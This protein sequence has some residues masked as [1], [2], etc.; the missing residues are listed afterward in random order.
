MSKILYSFLSESFL[1]CDDYIDTYYAQVTDLEL[2]NELH[3]YREFCIQ[4]IQ[5]MFNDINLYKHELKIFSAESLIDIPRLMQTA[6][7]M[8]QIT[9]P[10][11]IFKHSYR[12]SQFSNVLAEFNGMANEPVNRAS[13]SKTAKLLK[14]LAPMVDVGYVK[15]FPVDYFFEPK[16]EIPLTAPA[17]PDVL[18]ENIMRLYVDNADIKSFSRSGQYITFDKTLQPRREISIK[19]DSNPHKSFCYQLMEQKIESYDEATN[20]AQIV[21]SIPFYLPEKESFDAWVSQSLYKSAL[22]HH[23]TILKEIKFAEAFKSQ[24]ITSSPFVGKLLNCSVDKDIKSF[25]AECVL[26]FDLRFFENID[27]QT[28]MSIRQNDG[29]EFALFRC[30]LEK[31][32]RVLRAE[33]NTD[34]LKSKIADIS[35]EMMSVQIA[36]LD[37][38]VKN[39]KKGALANVVIGVAGLAGSIATSGF[40][41]LA[42]AIALANGYKTYAEYQQ[43]IRENPSFFLWKVK[44]KI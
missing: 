21:M 41:L 25:T 26:N 43:K 17:T 19:F 10:D 7:Y 32:L 38:K 22:I 11:P 6:L 24:Y 27:I 40:S 30:E 39:M 20:T 31:Q 3:K 35:H 34:V 14:K 28:L 12:N 33:Q 37:A 9:L 29:E 23:N 16:S 5:A 42:T 8:D 13:L 4:N 18:P 2:T 44:S 1:L 36:S 15:L